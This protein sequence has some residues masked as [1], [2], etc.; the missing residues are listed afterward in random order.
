ME[1]LHEKMFSSA[2][3]GFAMYDHIM[4]LK[5][6]ARFLAIYQEA[7]FTERAASRI[8]LAQVLFMSLKRE[9]P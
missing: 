4:W 5:F 3:F 9:G 7:M 6:R 8:N 2:T 1:L